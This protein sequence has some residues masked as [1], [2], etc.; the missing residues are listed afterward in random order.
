M[1]QYLIDPLTYVDYEKLLVLSDLIQ[2]FVEHDC[3]RYWFD[4]SELEDEFSLNWKAIVLLDRTNNWKI[5]TV[6]KPYTQDI[7][8][9]ALTIKGM[10]RITVNFL[11]KRSFIPIHTDTPSKKDYDDSCSL[12]NVI[13]PL[14]DNGWSIIDYQVLKNQKNSMLVFDGQVPHGA[15]NETAGMRKTVYLL[16]E[17]K[18]F[19]NDN[20]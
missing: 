14:D 2:K 16:I 18:Y 7:I 5:D 17:K 1:S 13:L 20:L 4:V 11:L 8:N 15:L 6:L 3:S 10:S 9:Y 12:Y 19:K